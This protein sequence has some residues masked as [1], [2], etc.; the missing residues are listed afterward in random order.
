M[1]IGILAVVAAVLVG[2]GGSSA[3]PIDAGPGVADAGPLCNQGAIRDCEC[4][5]GIGRQTCDANRHWH[6]CDCDTV[7]PYDAGAYVDAGP[8]QA[9]VEGCISTQNQC[10]EQCTPTCNGQ[11]C[12]TNNC[13]G[14]CSTTCSN[15]YQDCITNCD[16]QCSTQ[17]QTCEAGC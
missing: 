7:R 12:Q 17:E 2:C 11:V 15:E 5:T 9:C 14:S 16:S 6:V 3:G 10:S 1:R 13:L 8:D 4:L